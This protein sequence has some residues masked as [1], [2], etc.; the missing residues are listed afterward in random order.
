MEPIGVTDA[1]TRTPNRR[2][3]I[4]GAAGLAV[5]VATILTVSGVVVLAFFNPAWVDIAQRRAGVDQITGYPMSEVRRVTDQMIREIYV[6]PGTFAMTVDGSPVLTPRERSHMGDVRNVVL[7]F[8][9]VATLGAT[10]LVIAALRGRRAAW[11][12]RGVM[13]GSGAVVAVG[14]LVGVAL[15]V[16]FDA[17]FEA[18]HL[19]FFKPGS[20]TFDPRIERLV[21]IFP[22]QL[23][24]ESFTAVAMTGFA[25]SLVVFVLAVRQLRRMAPAEG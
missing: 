19:L 12:W 18:F 3:V 20:F 11:F 24:V 23:W 15:L 13:A 10:V 17:T 1:A 14:A 4:R 25:A 16:A 7:R 21:Q 22:D 9:L 2:R 8:L 5:A 6:G